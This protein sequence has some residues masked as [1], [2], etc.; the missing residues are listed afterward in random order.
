[1]GAGAS[2]GGD[3]QLLPPT[4][5]PAAIPIFSGLEE[6]QA[7]L[8][9]KGSWTEGD[10]D[11]IGELLAAARVFYDLQIEGA[12]RVQA[13]L[14]AKL[15]QSKSDFCAMYGLVFKLVQ[16]EAAYPRAMEAADRLEAAVTARGPQTRQAVNRIDVLYESSALKQKPPFDAMVRRLGEDA[17]AL[18]VKVAPLKSLARAFEKTAMKKAD[19]NRFD[20]DRLLDLVRGM[21]VFQTVEGVAAALE[22]LENSKELGWTV[23]RIK[24]RMRE[25]TGGGWADVL[26][27]LKANDD[28]NHFI[29]ELQLVHKKMLVTR[30]ELGGHDAYDDFR[31]AG[32]FLELV[33]E[34]TEAGVAADLERQLAEARKNRDGKKCKELKGL[35]EKVKALDAEIKRLT[36]AETAAFDDDDFDEGD[37]LHGELVARKA[38]LVELTAKA[39]G[40]D[41]VD[42]PVVEKV[43]VKAKPS[44]QTQFDGGWQT[45]AGTYKIFASGGTI[46]AEGNPQPWYPGTYECWG[47]AV[48]ATWKHGAVSNGTIATDGTISWTGATSST[49]K[50]SDASAHF[51]GVNTETSQDSKEAK[52][53]AAW[54]SE[55]LAL[56]RNGEKK[57]P[58]AIKAFQNCVALDANHSKAWFWLGQSYYLQNGSKNC[59]ASYEPYTRC[60]ALDPKHALAHGNLGSVLQYVRKD[61][62]GAE[63]HYRKAIELDPRAYACWNLS[64]ILENQKNDI[65]GAIE[66]TE[67]YIQAGNPDS[68]GKDRL[69][70]L[71]AKL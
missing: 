16:Q 64:L 43:S 1:M 2:A 34:K 52:S 41:A 38:E 71:R 69:A 54:Y 67:K 49:W 50:R 12:K 59:E 62:D 48:K 4:K 35:I 11:E 10:R 8:V 70:K 3:G 30:E 66:F 5:N 25:P 60:I 28:A 63:R 23:V 18:D 58:E 22:L 42:A 26:L 55:G 51:S 31:T 9:E 32:E 15:A 68:D 56:G 21:L 61:Y 13:Q 7:K 46:T 47:P 40:G 17:K 27:N 45:S 6:L 36:A 57:W 19:D 37:R 33:Q 65:P 29:C 14:E 39:A 44:A 53:P 24:N 20:S